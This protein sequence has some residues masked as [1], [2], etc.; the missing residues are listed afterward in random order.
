MS[1]N[2]LGSNYGEKVVKE[3]AAGFES[4]AVTVKTVNTTNIQGEHDSSTGDT[5]YHKR[6]TQYRAGETA[7]GDYSVAGTNN[8]ILVGKIPYTRQNVI[9]V[10][11][12]WNTVEEALELNQLPE[13]LRPVGESII[14]KAEQNL[15][16][17]I[18]GAAGL[19]TGVPGT[20]VDAWAD[21]AA[22]EA[23]LFDIGCPMSGK[24]YYQMGTGTSTALAGIQTGLYNDKRVAT[25]WDNA[26][27]SSP[28][29]NMTTIKS[30]ALINLTNGVCADRAGTLSGNPDV[31]WA[32]HKDTMIQT[33]PVTGL[34]TAGVIK[35]GETIECVGRY[36]VNPQNGNILFDAA[37]NPITFK[38]TVTADV[39]LSGGAGNVLVTNAAIFDAA[40]NNQY[41]NVS[42]AP[43]SGD[44]INILGAS[45]GLVKP[46]L[47]YH[48]NAVSFASIELPKLDAQDV[49]YQTKDGLRFRVS[50]G[51]D[52]AGNRNQMR[53]D[54]VPAFGVDQP[55]HV[56]RSY[57]FA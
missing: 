37:G 34:T 46:N 26:Q 21:V 53:V 3:I 10:F 11:H 48:E 36:H 49:T 7:N 6:K 52:F 18:V 55:L 5:I 57:G 15:N 35:K 8:D 16:T 1:T 45:A 54:F 44:V 51:S 13:L 20:A 30:N 38:W 50:R 14:V 27:V 43:V 42:S 25:A 23:I 41:D 33:I 4:S 28:M 32:T 56:G 22:S 24:K 29:A 12:D 17:F 47:F 31:T 9:T 2:V 19:T 40:S 39:T